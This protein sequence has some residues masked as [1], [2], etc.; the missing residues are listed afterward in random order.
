MYCLLKKNAHLLPAPVNGNWST[1][2]HCP[3]AGVMPLHQVSC[4][5]GHLWVNLSPRFMLLTVKIRYVYSKT[6]CMPDTFR[7]ICVGVCY[8]SSKSWP[9]WNYYILALAGKSRNK[10]S[11]G[12]FW[13][14]LYLFY[15]SDKYV[16]VLY[17]CTQTMPN[18]LVQKAGPKIWTIFRQKWQKKALPF[19][20]VHN[21]F[22]VQPKQTDSQITSCFVNRVPVP[23]MAFN[24][25]PFLFT[26]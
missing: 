23:P 25:S 24:V 19:W 15:T 16:Y 2:S 10:I 22:R 21:C 14:I 13:L 4:E 9:Y 1:S 3:V 11:N 8:R 18:V 7:K 12:S 6:T 20:A 17:S 5:A 26:V